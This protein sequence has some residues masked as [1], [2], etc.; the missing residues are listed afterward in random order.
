MRV[1]KDMIVDEL[2][3]GVSFAPLIKMAL[4]VSAMSS[5]MA[6]TL[7]ISTAGGGSTGGFLHP[8]IVS[9]PRGSLSG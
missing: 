1:E 5:M 4:K 7:G 3:V 6:L 2:A 9:S 8:K